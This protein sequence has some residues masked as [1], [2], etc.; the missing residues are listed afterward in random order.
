MRLSFPETGSVLVGEAGD[1]IGRGA[2]ASIYWVDEAA[3]I[4]RAALIDASLSATTNC[5]IDM[6]SVNGMANPFAIKRHSGKFE[7]FT[8]HWRDDPRKD[9]EW[10]AKKCAELDPVVIA[11][12][13]D[14]SYV[15]SV[16]GIVIPAPWVNAA[17]D[18]HTKL[19]IE[20]TG[21]RR[22]ALDV[23]D[24]GID[25][26]AFAIRHGMLLETT[27]SWSGKGGD[28]YRTVL[29][30]FA[31][32]DEF[33]AEV[34]VYDA[35][36]L[37][38]G[39]RGDARIINEARESAGKREIRAEPFRGSGA[40]YNPTGQLVPKRLNQDFFANLKAQ[41]W[42]ALRLRFQATHRAVVD[43]MPFDADEI[44]SINPGIPELSALTMEL[45]QPTY[46]INAVGKIVIDK[47]PPGTRSPN[48][49]DAVMIA[50]E[51]SSRC[52][53]TWMKLGLS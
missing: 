44:I 2:R 31:L 41:S 51:P 28:I 53:E 30:A 45:S 33:D 43:R 19:G 3:H 23:A 47:Q 8:F 4:E 27:L 7:V 22:G 34:F 20:P 26:D 46:S 40:V 18:A 1:Q 25:K 24:E 42:W 11:S 32:C 29:Q 10:Y 6:S 21:F 36:G 37:G 35:D 5:R 15:A 48:L 12:E 38:A 49:A 16:E 52:L 14:L 39:V 17:I 9:Q 13:I 50:F